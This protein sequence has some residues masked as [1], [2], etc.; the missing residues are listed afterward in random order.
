M[1]GKEFTASVHIAA[2]P[3]QVYEYFTKSEA[4]I[5]WMG[6]RASLDPKPGGEFSVDFYQARVRGRYLE[7]ER[8]RRLLISWGHEASDLLPPGSSTVEVT[9]SPQRG[10]TLVQIV[11]R[12]LPDRELPRHTLGWMHFLS[13]LETAGAGADPGPDP[14]LTSPPPEA[15]LP[16]PG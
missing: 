2:E 6:R 1:G 13:R 11:H 8:P 10:G 15:L 12:D 7:L 16:A 4:M 9:L 5:L 14:W 3:D